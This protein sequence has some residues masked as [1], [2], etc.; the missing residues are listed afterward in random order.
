[1]SPQVTVHTNDA[2]SAPPR[3][4]DAVTVTVLVPGAAAVPEITPVDR[5]MLSPAGS[6]VAVNVS[7]A[8]ADEDDADAVTSSDTALC[9]GLLIPCG[10]SMDAGA[11]TGAETDPAAAPAGPAAPARAPAEAVPAVPTA[12][13]VLDV[14]ADATFSVPLSGR[15]RDE[16]PTRIWYAPAAVVQLLPEEFQYARSR[17][18]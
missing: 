5:S 8:E 1:M 9:A 7:D 11:D 16:S 3:P 2:V 4:S 18:P 14:I 17:S 13:T 6:P 12:P 15:L 10:L